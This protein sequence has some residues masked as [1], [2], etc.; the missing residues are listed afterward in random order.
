MIAGPL[1]RLVPLALN[2]TERF[3]AARGL[4]SFRWG[5]LGQP[6]VYIPLLLVCVLGLAALVVYRRHRL[7]RA[8]AAALGQAAS[9]VDLTQAERL[10]LTRVTEAADPRPLTADHTLAMAFEEGVRHILVKR[11]T[12]N[13]PPQARRRVLDIIQALRIKLG[14]VAAKPTGG[15]GFDLARGDAVRMC[16]P[17]GG[18]EVA[19]TVVGVGDQDAAVRL[20]G[21]LPLRLGGPAVIRHLRGSDQ[22]EYHV[23]VTQMDDEIIRVR[24][25]GSPMKTNLRRFARVPLARP[26]HLA[27]YDFVHEAGPGAVPEFVEGTLREIAG[28][29][30]LLDAPIDLA[31]GERVLV[32]LHLGDERSLRGMGDVR[33]CEAP[34]EGEPAEIA[35][36]LTG[37][38]EPE[39]SRLVRETNAAGRTAAGTRRKTAAANT[40]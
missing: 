15:T 39:I 30:L 35:V 19:G 26:V 22:W 5:T 25:I 16:L 29:G 9:Q 36:E 34:K 6:S 18:T 7:R 21:S 4:D 33:R 1:A 24:L 3:E 28:P 10:M 8:L 37:M 32:I 14:F 13:L 17:G 20:Q 40:H 2:P 12:Q 11:E 31:V 38:T 27:R 23:S